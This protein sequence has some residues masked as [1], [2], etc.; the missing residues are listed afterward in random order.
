M[1][2]EAGGRKYV[3]RSDLQAKADNTTAN[4]DVDYMDPTFTKSLPIVPHDMTSNQLLV[5]LQMNHPDNAQLVRNVVE[6]YKDKGWLAAYTRIV[7]LLQ[8]SG[9]TTVMLTFSRRS[10]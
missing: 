8:Y 5:D 3:S 2:R 10:Y 1:A 7:W 6:E 4:I 9:K